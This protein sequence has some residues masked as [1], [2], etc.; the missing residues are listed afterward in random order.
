ME[1]KILVEMRQAQSMC[2]RDM[3]QPSKHIK[4]SDILQPE[5]IPHMM[6][7]S[8]TRM[9]GQGRIRSKLLDDMNFGFPHSADTSTYSK[10]SYSSVLQK[11][12]ANSASTQLNLAL[13]PNR[14]SSS[15]ENTTVFSSMTEYRISQMS[16]FNNSLSP[17]KNRQ[18]GE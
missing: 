3:K 10:K 12:K 9:S 18:R 5:P 15:R 14:K 1:Q 2:E 6:A 11:E 7:A 13:S 16:P 8:P 17:S 4:E